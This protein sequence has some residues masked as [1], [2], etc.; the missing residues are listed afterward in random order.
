MFD[1]NLNRKSNNRVMKP[2]RIGVE[3]YFKV[4]NSFGEGSVQAPK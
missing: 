3:A 2:E 4:T 1:G